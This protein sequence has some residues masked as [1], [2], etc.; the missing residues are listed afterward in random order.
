MLCLLNLY[1]Q[2]LPFTIQMFF[3]MF[4]SMLL[5]C[6]QRWQILITP[7][8]DWGPPKELIN[9]HEKDYLK[10]LDK[11]NVVN[12]KAVSLG[13]QNGN[14]VEIVSEISPGLR[15]VDAGKNNVVEG[16][17]VNVIPTNN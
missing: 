4:V 1:K 6:L 8:S 2:H 7:T 14:Y 10:V 12:I 16:Q 9:A 5:F 3:S 15:V 11:D 13:K 17:I